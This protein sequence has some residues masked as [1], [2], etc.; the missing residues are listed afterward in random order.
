MQSDPN[1]LDKLNALIRIVRELL[2]LLLPFEDAIDVFQGE[3][4]MASFVIPGIV[5]IKAKLKELEVNK[6]IQ[7][8]KPTLE[9]LKSSQFSN[10]EN[11]N[12]IFQLATILN[13]GFKL[14]WCD[15][16][17]SQRIKTLLATEANSIL[18]AAHGVA[19][20]V[21]KR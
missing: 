15:G 8:L 11:N 17:E 1:I 10:C 5:G 4:M 12:N 19:T 18:L 21:W 16:I 6:S 7:H 20:Y 2:I 3:N 9:K 13:L 14:S